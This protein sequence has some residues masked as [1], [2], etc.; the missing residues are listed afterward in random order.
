MH[1]AFGLFSLNIAAGLLAFSS[2]PTIN[3]GPLSASHNILFYLAEQASVAGGVCRPRSEAPVRVYIWHL[4]GLSELPLEQRLLLFLVGES[5]PFFDYEY[6]LEE[7]YVFSFCFCGPCIFT[8][9]FVVEHQILLYCS[10]AST[11]QRNR[12]AQ[13]HKVRADQ[14][15]TAQASR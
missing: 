14:S 15:A 9:Y 13:S 5:F 2:R 12:P 7:P 1:V 11:A 10:T 6:F 4:S 3:R 8:I